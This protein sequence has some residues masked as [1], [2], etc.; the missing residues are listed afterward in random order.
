MRFQSGST[1]SLANHLFSQLLSRVTTHSIPPTLELPSSPTPSS[2]PPSTTSPAVVPSQKLRLH[3]SLRPPDAR[4]G[5]RAFYAAFVG[6]RDVLDDG[7]PPRPRAGWPTRELLLHVLVEGLDHLPARASVARR[8]LYMVELKVGRKVY[9]TQVCP[10]EEGLGGYVR[11]GQLVKAR[12]EAEVLEA[13]S[14]SV[15]EGL[16]PP[17]LVATAYDCGL[18]YRH[19]V[20]GRVV[21]GVADLLGIVSE[22]WQPLALEMVDAEGDKV[23]G[24]DAEVATMH[25][26]VHLDERCKVKVGGREAE[27]TPV[28][29]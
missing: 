26:T 5:P 1:F 10:A 18:R 16:P 28:S 21:L 14:R 6:Q 19:R 25:V 2:G 13:V 8:N 3:V 22:G 23:V 7:E 15:N 27:P 24:I 9:A 20:V 4:R 12:V 17:C 11:M 29:E